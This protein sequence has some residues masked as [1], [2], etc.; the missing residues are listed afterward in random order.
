MNEI[1][2]FIPEGWINK[3][4]S[5][6][7]ENKKFSIVD[8]PFGTQLHAEEYTNIGIPVIRVTNLSFS[9]KFLYNSIVFISKQKS[10][11]LMRS[12]IVPGD[13]IIAKTGATIGKSSIFPDNYKRG[14][15][16]SS[17]LKIS[18]DKNKASNK[19]ILYKICSDFGQKSILDGAG[20]STRTTINITPFGNIK[21]T[22]P[23]SIKEQQKIAS[24]LENVDNNIDKTQ[25][26]IE[27]YE[28]MKQGLM[29]DLFTKGIDENGKPHTEFKDSELGEIPINWTVLELGD[30]AIKIT[31]GSHFSPK[32]TE[33]E[34]LIANVKDMKYNSF[35]FDSCTKISLDDFNDLESNNCSPQNN[36]VLLSKDG[37]IGRVIVYKSNQRIVLLSSIAIIRPKNH[38]ADYLGHILRSHYF[39]KQIFKLQSGSALKRIVLQDI[40]KLKFP[41]PNDSQE[42]IQIANIL[43]SID[44]KIQ[45]ENEYHFKLQKIKTGLMQDLLTGKVR[46]KT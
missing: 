8:G 39:D 26:I 22:I 11:E 27:K 45:S 13:I 9:G 23:Q 38:D 19:F 1:S 2:E 34:Y 12:G 24:I 31:D 30:I 7:S 21:F 36:D 5:E 17:C 46:V 15:I 41:F 32:A 10:E 28:M 3:S 29:Y 44:D 37:T 20:G 25:E 4:L 35:D 16:A 18:I 42:Q 33:S 14:I 43:S 40:K 6:I